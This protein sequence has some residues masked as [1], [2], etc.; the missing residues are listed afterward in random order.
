MCERL[1]NASV[2]GIKRQNVE[3][4]K[5]DIY[6]KHLIIDELFFFEL[7]SLLY[8]CVDE[9]T[10]KIDLPMVMSLISERSYLRSDWF[11]SFSIADKLMNFSFLIAFCH[12]PKPFAACRQSKCLAL[13]SLSTE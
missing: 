11:F 5:H 8:I 4:G 7:I 13:K 12:R 10:K 1:A 9:R 2:E 3:L 6:N